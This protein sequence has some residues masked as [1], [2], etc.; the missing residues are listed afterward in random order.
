M[1]AVE[2]E[3]GPPERT[4][5]RH[6]TLESQAIITLCCF[7]SHKKFVGICYIYRR[8]THPGTSLL[9]V[10]GAW[11]GSPGSPTCL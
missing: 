2:V 7:L 5:P 6:S 1:P 8:Q 3:E 10:K 4:N 11:R 9:G